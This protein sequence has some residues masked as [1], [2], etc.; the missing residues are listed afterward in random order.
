MHWPLC[1]PCPVASA[2]APSTM[3][4]FSTVLSAVQQALDTPPGSERPKQVDEILAAVDSLLS[5]D[6]SKQLEC[7]ATVLEACAAG[8]QV[9]WQ[10]H[11]DRQLSVR[12]H[13]QRDGQV[14][15]RVPH[16]PLLYRSWDM[17]C[18]GYCLRSKAV[19]S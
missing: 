9:I 19:P 7:D 8:L 13:R 10:K 2:L 16:L 1:A 15:Q 17:L 18:Q 5:C 14:Q 4:T 11:C 3:E 12:D 6:D